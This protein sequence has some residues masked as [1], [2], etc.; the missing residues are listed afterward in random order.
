MNVQVVPQRMQPLV[1]RPRRAFRDWRRGRPF[2][3][4]LW[5]IVAGYLVA[6]LAMAGL[7]VVVVN[8]PGRTWG[9]VLGIGLVALGLTS[10][11]VPAYRHLLGVVGMIAGT[12]TLLAA[13]LGAYGVG[14]LLAI[15]GGA[16]TVAWV[17]KQ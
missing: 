13:N 14:T 5:M 15:I 8:M 9:M 7:A 2:W 12:G 6:E 10:W 4:G 17:E 16:M 3:G 11:F 1:S